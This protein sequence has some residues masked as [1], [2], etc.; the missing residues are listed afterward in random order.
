MA[1]RTIQYT[2]TKDE[3]TPKTEQQAG[4]QGETNVTDVVFTVSNDLYT[5]ITALSGTTLYRIQATDGAGGFHS[6]KLLT[7]NDANHTV[8][9][10]IT[11][12]LS[13]AGG[14]CYLHLII[15]KM[16]SNTEHILYSFPARLRFEN[17]STGSPSESSYRQDI[18][19]ALFKAK[20][21]SDAAIEA[22]TISETAKEEAVKAKDAAETAMNTAEYAKTFA[23][24]QATYAT[25]AMLAAQDAQSAAEISA[26]NA[27]DSAEL[28]ESMN[29][30]TQKYMEQ[31]ETAANN[32]MHTVE[33]HNAAS[34]THED[35][36]LMANDAKTIAMGKANSL[37]FDT[38]EQLDSWVGIN[39]NLYYTKTISDTFNYS[40]YESFGGNVPAVGGT[41]VALPK[42]TY[43]IGVSDNRLTLMTLSD[44]LVAGTTSTYQITVD[45]ATASFAWGG[46]I[47]ANETVTWTATIQIDKGTTIGYP[48]NAYTRE[49]GI[50]KSD[51][52]PGDLLLVE[53]TGVPD[54]YWDGSAF[55]EM[56]AQSAQKADQTY[57]PTSENA[58]SGKAVAEAISSAQD[59]YEFITEIT[60][61]GDSIIYIEFETP[62]KAVRIISNYI[63]ASSG[64]PHCWYLNGRTNTDSVVAVT[65]PNKSASESCEYFAEIYF[66]N[67][68]L[69]SKS[70]KTQ[71]VYLGSDVFGGFNM[72]PIFQNIT[73][74]RTSAEYLAGSKLKV[75]GVK[76]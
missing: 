56:E 36:R 4:L 54:G 6:S 23:S 5:A 38:K 21:A 35:I 72:S 47:P 30:N 59:K 63:A 46:T 40:D 62:M 61:E 53:E 75:Y 48:M 52:K 65:A 58:Q 76:A 1:I 50:K 74:L 27:E 24:E 15:S 42:G 31:A 29:A 16:Q 71:N 7:L 10:S 13:N 69:F 34:G 68:I 55:V 33:V 66:D 28:A 22:Q 18:S 41:E 39:E 25:N 70:I 20:Q 9:F 45:E 49:D 60:L 57:S 51:L 12:E 19:G 26:Q 37:V 8:T 43:T 64:G 17:T 14:I 44:Y 73:R 67:G 2:V 32:A 11:D 3:I